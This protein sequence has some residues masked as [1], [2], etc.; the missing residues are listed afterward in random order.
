MAT[1]ASLTQ[2]QIGNKLP[3]PGQYIIQGSETPLSLDQANI[4][5]VVEYWDASTNVYLD[6]RL[7]FLNT[8]LLTPI[9][10]TD[11]Y[12]IIVGYITANP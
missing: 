11:S 8:F 10:V 5:G 3:N 7:I 1:I 4:I 2:V 6:A 9:V 12:A